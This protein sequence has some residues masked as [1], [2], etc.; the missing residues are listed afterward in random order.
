[1][2]YCGIKHNISFGAFQEKPIYA[3]VVTSFLNICSID[4][5]TL[6]KERQWTCVR[7]H[8]DE[9]IVAAGDSAGRVLVWRNPFHKSKMGAQCIYHWHTLPCQDIA[10]TPAG[11][12]MYTGGGEHVLVKWNIEN[13]NIRHYLPRLSAEIMH[14]TV[15]ADNLLVAVSTLDNGIQIIESQNKLRCVLQQLVWGVIPTAD[16]KLFPAGLNFDRRT[17]GLVLNGRPGHLQFYS[18]QSEIL[19]FNVDITQRNILTQERAKVITNTEVTHC[20]LSSDGA[21][22]AS[23]ETRNESG[24]ALELRLK[25][26]QFIPSKQRFSLNTSVEKPHNGLAFTVQFKPGTD[27]LSSSEETNLEYMLVT[28]GGD[29]KFRIW[30]PSEIDSVHKKGIVWGCGSTGFYRDKDCGVASFSEDGSLLAVSFAETLTIWDIDN[31]NIK[32]TLTR[33]HHKINFVQFGREE[34]CHL[35]TT[36]TDNELSVWNLLNVTLLWHITIQTSI[37]VSDPCSSYQAVFTKDCGVFIFTPLSPEPIY[38]HSKI[39]YKYVEILAAVFIP[40]GKELQ[41]DINWLRRSQ[42]YYINSNQ[43][44]YTS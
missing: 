19:L 42:L 39:D 40:R 16:S 24:T 4:G 7:C 22:M 41:C 11:S 37:L 5:Y 10:L 3:S 35:V 36:A 31:I 13:P 44:I 25:I 26:W 6:A 43:V 2:S 38:T 15:S 32:T 12:I 18:P 9:S 8:Q 28:T 23:I 33:Q 29:K 20:S 1:I 21:W 27:Q 30:T 17:G 14:I 34:C